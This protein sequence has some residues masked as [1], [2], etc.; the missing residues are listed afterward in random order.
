MASEVKRV[1]VVGAGG[2]GWWTAVALCRDCRGRRLEVWDDDTFEGGLGATRLPS[3][4][5][6]AM[7]KVDYLKGWV[8]MVMGDVA[9]LCVDRRFTVQDCYGHDLSDTLVVDCTDMPLAERRVLWH[10]AKEA[11]AQMLRVS[12]DGAAGGVV[13]V[14]RGLPLSGKPGGGYAERPDLGLSLW[15]GGVGARAVLRVLDGLEVGD[16]Q[17]Q[18]GGNE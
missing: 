15:A 5:D 13:V 14:S 4:Y 6:P 10:Y 9:P 1:V 7:K 3:V 2:V 16:Q 8:E 18:F 12:Y 11:G 17:F